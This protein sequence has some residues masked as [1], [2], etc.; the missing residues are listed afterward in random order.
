MKQLDYTSSVHRPLPRGVTCRSVLRFGVSVA[1]DSDPVVI[2][3]PLEIRVAGEP[4][5]V[6]MRTPGNDRELA[7][8]FLYTEGL[9]RS[10]DDI[11]SI[12]H[13]GRPGEPSYGNTIDVVLAPGVSFPLSLEGNELRRRGTIATAACG[14]CGRRTIDDLLAR[15]A[16]LEDNT[17]ISAS[18][19]AGLFETL[20]SRQ[21]LFHHTGGLHAAALFD[22]SGVLVAL[23]E[24][25]GRHN[26][27]DKVIGQLLLARRVPARGTVLAVSGRA[28]FEIVQ[29]ALVTGV[30]IVASVSAASSLAIDLARQGKMTL[31]AFVR[32][33]RMNVYAGS[34]RIVP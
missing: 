20:R 29:K 12:H 5:A 24:D 19:I 13:C 3:E 17:V 22:S 28:S 2:E 33:G 32:Q 21:T 8:G 1:H 31:V 16:P 14:V 30:A 34:E 26:A 7:L 23:H 18:T 27:V 6:I 4:V 15:C 9:V 25:V 11:G 10:V